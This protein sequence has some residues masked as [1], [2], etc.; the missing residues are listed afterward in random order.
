MGK[1]HHGAQQD[2]CI[3][4]ETNGAEDFSLKAFVLHAESLKEVSAWELDP[5]Q[6]CIDEKTGD[7]LQ[8]ICERS[9]VPLTI[10]QNG[11]STNGSKNANI[12]VISSQTEDQEMVFMEQNKSKD[13]M[14]LWLGICLGLLALILGMAVLFSMKG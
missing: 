4:T 7:Y 12:E 3:L 6:Q 10:Y 14:V 13:G 8:F 5:R 11:H 1:R 2:V 9:Y